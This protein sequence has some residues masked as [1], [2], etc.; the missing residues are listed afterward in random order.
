MA[1]PQQRH[2][3]VVYGATG[4]TGRFVVDH[5]VEEIH[6]FRA[7]ASGTF[8][9]ALAGRNSTT[10]NRLRSDL[11]AKLPP[12]DV[13]AVVVADISDQLGLQKMAEGARVVMSCVGPYAFLGE[14]VVKAIL[15]ANEALKRQGEAPVDYLDLCGEP[16]WIEEMVLRYADRATR[17]GCSIIHAAAFDSVPAD[18]GVLLAKR[19]LLAKGATP[20]S[21]EA[22]VRLHGSFKH[23]MGIHYATY[24]A[25][26]NGF[27]TR[28]HLSAVR[29]EL[30]AKLPKPKPKPVQDGRSSGLPKRPGMLGGAINY[31]EDQGL[32]VL[33]FFFSDPSVVRLSQA[34]AAKLEQHDAPPV[35]FAFWF[36][37]PSLP[38]LLFVTA[39]LII[40]GLVSSFSI[41]RKLLLRYPRAFTAGMV[42]HEGP[43]KE[44]LENSG[45]TTTMIARGYSQDA[46]QRGDA[47]GQE[48][49]D[50]R[51]VVKITGPEAGY[52]ATPILFAAVA[53]T[54]LR[55]RSKLTPG[56][57]TPA[58]ALAHTSL[59][60]ELNKG[61]RV[62][63][64]VVE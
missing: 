50:V 55:E 2:S 27:S 29:K 5:I 34:L 31:A 17:L 36:A 24:E 33:P 4:F 32:Y 54:V 48:G 21:L 63:F 38:V 23:R 44:Q 56:V 15:S 6:A 28:K 19:Q 53:R 35:V 16:A 25:A 60:D 42:T 30:Y 26:V 13:P 61:G 14:P 9:W 39:A 47:R 45:F 18:I 41:G 10:L 59:V 7:A 8:S 51:A 49:P 37:I 52:V 12:Q 46:L 22:F 1:T 3:L 57:V 40:F 11:E 20:T 43:T 58:V 64:A 62:K